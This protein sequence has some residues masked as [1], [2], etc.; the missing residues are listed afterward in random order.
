MD[1]TRVGYEI[2]QILASKTDFQLESEFLK[3][4]LMKYF[5]ILREFLV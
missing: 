4:H 3:F 2:A 1:Q 5:N